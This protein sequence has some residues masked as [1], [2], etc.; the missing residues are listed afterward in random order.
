MV[1]MIAFTVA[2]FAF[3]FAC[4]NFLKHGSFGL[5]LMKSDIANSAK[6]NIKGAAPTILKI[7]GALF[8]IYF[9]STAID[10]LN[11]DDKTHPQSTQNQEQ[12]IE[13]KKAERAAI[14]RP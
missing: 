3:F 7:G 10:L 1:L 12:K 13:P 14:S 6:S 2:L 5:S 11:R 8:L 9:Y 4:I